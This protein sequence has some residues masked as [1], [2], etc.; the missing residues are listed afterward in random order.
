M[1]RSNNQYA[2]LSPLLPVQRGNVK[3]HNRQLSVYG[4]SVPRI[5]LAY[6]YLALTDPGAFANNDVFPP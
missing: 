5:H 6:Y 2:M 4:L 1:E 3:I